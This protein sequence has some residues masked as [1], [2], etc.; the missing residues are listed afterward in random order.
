M[1]DYLL[2]HSPQP[3]NLDCFR[4]N[5][6][7]IAATSHSSLFFSFFN[8]VSFLPQI[9]HMILDLGLKK[10]CVGVHLCEKKLLSL[11]GSSWEW[12]N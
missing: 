7:N 5:P 11:K 6:V 3:H 8:F 2:I 10:L 4:D 12:N 1:P 9:H